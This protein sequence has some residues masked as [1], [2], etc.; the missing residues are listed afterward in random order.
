MPYLLD[1]HFQEIMVEILWRLYRKESPNKL[2]D[3]GLSEDITKKF[4]AMKKK[5]FFDDVRD[6][7]VNLNSSV[8]KP[9]YSAYLSTSIYCCKSN[10]FDI[11][12]L[13]IVIQDIF[14]SSSTNCFHQHLYGYMDS[15]RSETYY[16]LGK[17]LSSH[18]IL[19][20]KRGFVSITIHFYNFIG[21]ST[22]S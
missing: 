11:P 21:R 4:L 15:L 18:L 13:I 12:L 7:L 6:F 20:Q 3:L 16:S 22:S 10:R 14:L 5:T 17:Y 9:R 19:M 1:F 2:I 8:D